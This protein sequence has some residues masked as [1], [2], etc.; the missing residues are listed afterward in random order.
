MG[1]RTSAPQRQ[2]AW[3][4]HIEK[5]AEPKPAPKA[6][7]N[8]NVLGV[9]ENGVFRFNSPEAK[10]TWDR[11]A[12]QQGV[13]ADTWLQGEEIDDKTRDLA[14]AN[15]GGATPPMYRGPD[16]K[17]RFGNI[18]TIERAEVRDHR[19]EHIRGKTMDQI[20]AAKMPGEDEYI[21]KRKIQVG[22]SLPAS[23]N[24]NQSPQVVPQEQR[25]ASVPYGGRFAAMPDEVDEPSPGV[26]RPTLLRRFDASSKQAFID[27]TGAGTAI[28]QF[29]SG[30]ARSP[31]VLATRPP[32][33]FL[34]SGSK[35]AADWYRMYEPLGIA[36]GKRR[37]DFL[38]PEERKQ[39]QTEWE[40]LSA[41]QQAAYRAMWEEKQREFIPW[42]AEIDRE[43]YLPS[44]ETKAEHVVDILGG[45]TGSMA[46][47]ENWIGMEAGAASNTLRGRAI[48]TVEEAAIAAR[49]MDNLALGVGEATPEL[50]GATSLNK[51]D[52]LVEDTR[53]DSVALNN[54]SG[55]TA[56]TLAETA[57]NLRADLEIAKK[58]F[59]TLKEAYNLP[60]PHRGIVYV[61][62]KAPESADW[63]EFMK[64][65]PD[66]IWLPETNEFAVPAIRYVNPNTNG[67]HLIRL[68]AGGLLGDL[69]TAVL[70]DT[71]TQMAVW[72]KAKTRDTLL[73][74]REALRQNPGYGKIIYEVK[75][76]AAAKKARHF[77]ESNFFTDI[78]IVKVRGQ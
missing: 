61:K 2:S 54:A 44:P 67:R 20:A 76:E 34:Q 1:P 13:S 68:D 11:W 23:V 16:G 69:E 71:K 62:E 21:A 74:L 43:I 19:L 53:P 6:A 38:S 60:E 4:P 14:L 17:Y 32:D 12:Y 25:K 24:D 30:H 55:K 31:D 36:G 41:G 48:S 5:N 56:S 73:R 59:Y 78:V 66:V 42:R 33:R 10:E 39:W 26:E 40:L 58:K 46:S 47:P 8:S 29:K 50:T 45:F 52:E 72:A 37:I 70:T 57:P 28:Q 22:Q 27:G 51:L 7:A 3:P 77:I 35:G 65:H 64:G 63:V 9:W 49:G 15:I 18:R 75:T